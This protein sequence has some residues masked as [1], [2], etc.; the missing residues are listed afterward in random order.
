MEV[1][2]QL[3]KLLENWTALQQA[4]EAV[5]VSVRWVAIGVVLVVGLVGLFRARN[6]TSW[7]RHP[8]RFS[9]DP[10]NPL[11]LKGRVQETTN[12]LAACVNTPLVELTGESGSGKTALVRSGFLPAA[13]KDGRFRPFYLDVWGRDWESGPRDTLAAVLERSLTDTQRTALQLTHPIARA[14]V[15][16]V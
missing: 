7:L 4:L 14:D 10:G 3:T 12:L 16:P 15:F 2:N 5:P 13:K 1:L 8:E 6:M 11:H 9:I